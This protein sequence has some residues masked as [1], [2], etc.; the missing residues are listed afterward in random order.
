MSCIV[1]KTEIND[2]YL[3]PLTKDT[4]I[5]KIDFDFDANICSSRFELLTKD[6]YIVLDIT[7]EHRYES[8]NISRHN[9]A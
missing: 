6:L 8:N 3:N 4:E 1:F 7:V 9:F 2:I 5:W